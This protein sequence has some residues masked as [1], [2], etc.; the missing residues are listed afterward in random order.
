METVKRVRERLKRTPIFAAHRRLGAK[1]VPFAGWEMPVQYRGVIEEHRAVRNRAGLFDVSHMGEIEIDGRD[2]LALCQ[3]LLSNDLSRLNPGGAQYTLL[4]NERGGVVDDLLVYRLAEDRFFLCV[5]AANTA[6]DAQWI[7]DRRRGNV[8]VRDVSDTYIQLAL[9]GPRS[10]SILQQL[11]PVQVDGIQPFHFVLGPVADGSCLISRT[12][13]TGEDGF[14]LYCDPLHGERLWNRLLEVGADFGLCPVGLGARDT[15]RLE[16]ALS[17]YGHEL[18]DETTPMEAGLQWVVKFSK[19]SFV[20]REPLLKQKD[21][22]LK[23]RLAG[24]EMVEPG[25]AR[26]GYA[27]IRD[28]QQVGQITSGTLSPTL[29]KAIALGYLQAEEACLDRDLQVEVRGRRIG[30]RVRRLPF[31]RRRSSSEEQ[32]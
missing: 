28:G 7:L 15:L 6:K 3:R 21:E 1:M 27:I 26:S 13:Y 20:G 9:Q 12:G 17:L 18:D 29:G 16:S 5:N 32:A 8:E 24:L 14:E 19:E 2:A 11:T 23:R 22:G 25:I 31:Y 10:P 4:L 30:A